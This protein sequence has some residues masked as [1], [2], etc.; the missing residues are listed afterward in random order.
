[1]KRRK[2]VTI[3]T[4]L[5][6]MN[7]AMQYCDRIIAIKDGK[8]F[9]TGTPREVLTPENLQALFRVRAEL[10]EIPGQMPYIRYLGAEL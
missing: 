3:F 7:M 10:V 4:S 8:I 9:A 1:M 2:D 5:H 6:D